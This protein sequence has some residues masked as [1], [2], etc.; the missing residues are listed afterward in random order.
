M[1]EKG[2]FET[3]W[4]TPSHFHDRIA[5]NLSL[6]CSARFFPSM[7]WE[8]CEFKMIRLFHSP[9]SYFS[10]PSGTPHSRLNCVDVHIPVETKPTDD[11]RGLNVEWKSVVTLCYFARKLELENVAELVLK[12]RQLMKFLDLLTGY[13]VHCHVL[14]CLL[15]QHDQ[16]LITHMSHPP[17]DVD[18][19]NW[20]MPIGWG[21][22]VCFCFVLVIY[23][24]FVFFPPQ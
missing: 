3:P 21:F 11:G 16:I 15:C 8:N 6:W 1:D 9:L 22:F 2:P 12:W 7:T 4:V 13:Y 10:R 5:N 19:P 24:F 20:V 23:L 17:F 14:L 18:I